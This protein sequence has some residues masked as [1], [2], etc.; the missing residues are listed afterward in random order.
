MEIEPKPSFEPKTDK[1]HTLRRSLPPA[2]HRNAAIHD[3]NTRPKSS[4]AKPHQWKNIR[5]DHPTKSTL[6]IAA[7][8]QRP[9]L[10]K[11][12]GRSN[13]ANIGTH[14]WK[15]VVQNT[16]A[17]ALRTFQENRE[18]SRRK[19]VLANLKGE[20]EDNREEGWTTERGRKGKTKRK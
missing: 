3:S 11:L 4:R 8:N 7:T 2:A 1:P 17:R 9:K 12:V 19:L 10:W 13:S 6:E 16:R 18:K 5:L 14:R 15:E 20:V